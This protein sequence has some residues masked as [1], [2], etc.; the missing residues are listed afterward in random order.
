MTSEELLLVEKNGF[1]KNGLRFS[2]EE[3]QNVMPMNLSMKSLSK[4]V[5]AITF[6]KVHSKD[7]LFFQSQLQ[8]LP[9]GKKVNVSATGL[10]NL[11]YIALHMDND[12]IRSRAATLFHQILSG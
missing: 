1:D 5:D 7:T 11:A 6:A 12:E 3:L 4:Y 2:I 8:D 9:F 10:G